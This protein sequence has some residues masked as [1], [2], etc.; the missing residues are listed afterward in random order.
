MFNRLPS[1]NSIK[2]FEA[3]A[4]LKSFKQAASEL[5]VSPTAVSHQVRALEDNLKIRLFE[6]RTRSVL[7]TKEGEQLAASANKLLQDLLNVVNEL[8]SAPNTITL[9]TTSSFAAMW[10]VPN[11]ADFQKQNPDI[12]VKIMADD[13]LIDIE[14]DRRVDMVIRYG[15]F[16]PEQLGASLL[17]QEALGFFATPD[18][19][20]AHAGDFE[21]ATFHSTQFKNTD[22]PSLEIEPL[23]KN[24]LPNSTS[25]SAQINIR[26]YDD[27]NQTVQAALSGQ[28]IAIISKVLVATPLANGW[29]QQGL[30]KST[31]ELSGLDYYCIIPQR[32]QHNKAALRLESWLQ[33]QLSAAK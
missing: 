21:N 27:E 16:R 3:A 33:T 8:T 6:R 2:T 22:L 31:E 19:W 28:G 12:D 14:N 4:R 32:N 26:Y 29:L 9:G 11:L 15:C 25:N 13:S 17:A 30:D 24:S 23:L 1:L 5:N 20:L 7:L 10:L 18:Y